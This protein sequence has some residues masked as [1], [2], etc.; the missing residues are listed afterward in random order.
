MLTT[1][2]GHKMYKNGFQVSTSAILYDFSSILPSGIAQTNRQQDNNQ[3]IFFEIYDDRGN[4]ISYWDSEG[5][6]TTILYGYNQTL[7]IAVIKGTTFDGLTQELNFPTNNVSEYLN[8]EIVK[9]S[10]LDVNPSTENTLITELDNFRKQLNFRQVSYQITTY[11]YDTLLGVTTLTPPT[12]MTQKYI[13]NSVTN[14]LEKIVDKDDNILKEF[15]Y[16]YK[17]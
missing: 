12:G 17:H 7:P 11:T 14:K 9:K 13:Y 16:N 5:I 3:N 8:L 15:K 1:S 4:L 6:P 10:N 2:L